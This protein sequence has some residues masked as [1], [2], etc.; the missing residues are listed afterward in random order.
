MN[1]GALDWSTVTDG[2]A[3]KGVWGSGLGG[4]IMDWE[5]SGLRCPGEDQ[6]K[7]AGLCPLRVGKNFFHLFF[8]CP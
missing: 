8:A 3:I 7:L 4:E 6:G 5:E 2:S 1:S